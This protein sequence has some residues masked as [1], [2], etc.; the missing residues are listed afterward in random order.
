MKVVT[1]N[2]NS[3]KARLERVVNYLRRTHPDVVCLQELKGIAENFPHLAFSDLGYTASVF[4][5]KTYNGVAILSKEKP[6][7]IVRGFA[8]D[9]VDPAA[10]FIKARFGEW[11]IASAY[12]PNGQAVGTEK[13][14]YKLDWLKRFRNHLDKHHSPSEKIILT[15]DFNVAPEDIDVHDPER[16]RGKILFSD[17]E[18]Q[19]LKE[20]CAFGLFDT[21][22]KH[23]KEGNH[24]TWWD[25]R[26]LSFPR[27][28]G[29]RIDF[30]LATKKAMELCSS[31]GIDR[32]ERKGNLPSDHAPVFAT[33]DDY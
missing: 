2:V 9:V 27:N 18:K 28:D 30:I 6:T 7:E 10:R 8:D 32:E 17:P 20:L 22:R 29:L 21:F 24:F 31:A 26:T 25:Y 23:H 4:G 33:F 13:Y 1:W 19:A 14:A 12:I 16:W 3:V 5:Q 11:L 15:G